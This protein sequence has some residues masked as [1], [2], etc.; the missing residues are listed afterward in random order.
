MD[1]NEKIDK[2]KSLEKLIEEK[3]TLIKNE[4]QELKILKKQYDELD[5]SE[6]PI[7]MFL[8]DHTMPMPDEKD[9]EYEFV[10]YCP[11]LDEVKYITKHKQSELLP[12]TVDLRNFFKTLG[13]PER[14][15]PGRILDKNSRDKL[16]YALTIIMNII[17]DLF[18]NNKINNWNDLGKFLNLISNYYSISENNNIKKDQAKVLKLN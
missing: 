12:N 15:W 18:S 9:Y 1:R 4:K 7:L 16:E 5:Q 10:Y 17:E 14:I 6:L 11:D 3:E 13:M 8:V 2:R